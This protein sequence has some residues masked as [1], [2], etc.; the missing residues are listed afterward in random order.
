MKV[1]VFGASGYGGQV[2]LR[3]LLD[4]PEVSAVLPVSST[5]AGSAVDERDGGIGPDPE[6]KLPADRRLLTRDEAAAEAPAAVFSA[7]P[8]G[9]SA[10]FCEPFFGRS[11]VF[12]LSADFRLRDASVH[13]AAYGH[14]APGSTLRDTAVY[15]LS[16]VYRDKIRNSDLIAVPGCYPTCTLLPL[17]PL[18]GAGML[19]SPITVNSLSGISGAGRSAKESSLYVERSENSTAYNPGH[20]HRHHPEMVQ[21]LSAAGAAA[22]L[23]F[24]PHLVPMRRGMLSTISMPVEGSPDDWNSRIGEVLT[25]FYA[26]STFITLT[27]GR[28]PATRDVVGSNRCDIGWLVEG[29]NSGTAMVYLFSVI[30]NL[31]KGASGQAVQDFNIRFGF[32]EHSGLPL[33]GEV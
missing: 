12:D 5:T 1:A 6:G 3:L 16:E 8:H 9:A 23:F 10:E 13:E 28:I 21:E 20:K 14:P 26:G 18:A 33:R 30:D 19:K 31:V 29:S 24:T 7:L 17:I 27:G 22:P 4:H 15:G 32:S 2:L 11:A 25:G